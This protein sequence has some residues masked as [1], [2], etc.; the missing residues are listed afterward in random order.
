MGDPQREAS[1]ARRQTLAATRPGV[2]STVAA[3]WRQVLGLEAVGLQDHFFGLGGDSLAAVQMLAQVEAVLAPIDFIEF[4]EAPT[5]SALAAAVQ[6]TLGRPAEVD[7][8]HDHPSHDH[9]SHDHPRPAERPAVRR[10]GAIAGQDD[11]SSAEAAPCSYAQESL[12]FLELGQA[13][14]V[15][16]EPIAVRLQGPVDAGALEAGL[17]TIVARHGALR[18]TLQ[19]RDGRPV[20]MIASS[21][22]LALERIDLRAHRDPFAEGRQ[23]AESLG[24]MPFDLERGPLIRAQLLQLD[25]AEHLLVLVLHHVVCDGWSHD[26]MLQELG[27]LYRARRDSRPPSLPA[28]SLQYSDFAAWQRDRL[29]GEELVAERD[30]WRA[31]LAGAPTVVRL[32]VDRRHQPPQT[33]Q[34]AT[35]RIRLGLDLAQAVRDVCRAERVTPYTLLLAAWSTLLYRRS[36][37]DDLLLSGPMANR[38]A[39]F[40]HVIGFFA[41]TV[42]VRVRLGGNP[43]FQTLLRAVSESVFA[44]YEHQH[45]PLD[46]VVDAVRPER[47]PGVNP[48]V[49]VNFRVRTGELPK[50]DL[51]DVATRRIPVD[52]G[53]ARFDLALELHVLDDGIEAEF[54]WSTALFHPSTIQRLAANFEQ[55][56]RQGLAAPSTRLLSFTLAPEPAASA[57]QAQIGGIR[58]FRDAGR[59][60]A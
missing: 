45:V 22:D 25:D 9:P 38:E 5:I 48:L 47:V 35:H 31:Q 46:V 8:S 11:A 33:F 13:A 14:G 29:Q 28:L 20:Q 32:P 55:L 16:N 3:I 23:L 27:E 17:Q 52:L 50:P 34:G 56:L 36:G 30:F 18:T 4:I 10:R 54:N 43:S 15:Y 51:G 44:S 60:S 53:V 58:R 6:R 41:N 19:A 2:E 24:R 49:Q 26:L 40:R 42:V 12:W 21:L 59:S 1:G 37:Q 57:G 39:R 7:P